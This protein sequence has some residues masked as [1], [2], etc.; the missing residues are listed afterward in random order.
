MQQ[1]TDRKQLQC[2]DMVLNNKTR[3]LFCY[4]IDVK[5]PYSFLKM[6]QIAWHSPYKHEKLSENV[7]T[8]GRKLRNLC[9]IHHHLQSNYGRNWDKQWQREKKL[10][11][12]KALELSLFKKRWCNVCCC[13]LFM[14]QPI[15]ALPINL[16]T[17][18][19]NYICTHCQSRGLGISLH[20]GYPWGRLKNWTISSNSQAVFWK[21][22]DHAKII[23]VQLLFAF[24]ALLSQT[25]YYCVWEN[26]C[27]VDIRAHI[28]MKPQNSCD[29]AL[30]TNITDNSH[31][32][33][34][35]RKGG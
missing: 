2:R 7:S 11:L 16:P 12:G 8:S 13:L 30:N 31:L 15:P 33:P 24:P 17:G 1:T 4:S 10:P 25:H 35:I 20:Q 26:T 21:T 29:S 27:L 19:S 3:P 23:I 32:C 28:D 6:Y 14:H 9:D 22:H 34:S 5:T 18:G